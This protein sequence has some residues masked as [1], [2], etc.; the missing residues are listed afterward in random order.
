[1][2]D[3]I[4]RYTLAEMRVAT[5]EWLGEI[6]HEVDSLGAAVLGSAHVGATFPDHVI[7]IALNQ[8]L[9]ARYIDAVLNDVT[10]FADEERIDIVEGQTEY[11]FPDD[12]AFL[13]GLYWKDPGLD[14]EYAPPSERMQMYM[15]DELGPDLQLE[16]CGA[17][18]FR[19]NLNYFVLNEA[20]RQDN[21]G[22]VLCRYVKW[23]LYL[24][25]DDQVVETQ[26]ARLLQELM[27][28]DAVD[29]LSSIR[30]GVTFAKIQGERLRWETR[31]GL[32]IRNTYTPANIQFVYLKHPIRRMVTSQRGV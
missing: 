7:N 22:G 17:P 8:A 24:A 15:S 31:L 29:S 18:T 12:Y 28:L 23:C 32:A 14:L 6:N 1:M 20:P 25:V 13:R 11:A 9:T 16:W 21:P 30:V 5:R 2:P 26:W 10:V 3:S 19:L 27:I 4:G